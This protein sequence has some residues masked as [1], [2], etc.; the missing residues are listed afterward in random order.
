MSNKKFLLS[1]VASAIT[2]TGFSAQAATEEDGFKFGGSVRGNYAYNEFNKDSENKYGDFRFD[3]A[4]I[5]ISGKKDDFGIAAEYRFKSGVDFIKYGYGFYDVNDHMQVQVGLTQVPFGNPGMI[6]NSWWSSIGYYMGFEDHFDMGAK[7]V[8]ARN[9]WNTD[10]AFFKGSEYSPTEKKSYSAN[11]FTGEVNG[12]EYSNEETNQFNI[13]QTYT[14]NYENGRT[15][16]GGSV[17]GGQL[18]DSVTKKDGDRFAYAL[19]LDSTY[20]GWGVQAQA[21]HY[22]FNANQPRDTIALAAG[23]SA[24]EI[25]S[26]AQ[27]YIVNVYKTIPTSFGF[28]KI[29]NDFNLLTPEEAQFSDTYQNATGVAVSAGPIFAQAD[30]VLGKNSWT[31][32][33]GPGI[34]LA[35]TT[36]QNHWDK[37]FNINVGYY[38]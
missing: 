8:Y 11:V 24:Y 27:L 23:G 36:E 22:E 10:I 14:I 35:P 32:G 5:N 12:T 25:A 15:I 30:F 1:L 29:Y 2:L 7:F 28:V 37:T 6:S 21:M 33:R 17:Q 38:F 20:N 26:E 19:H 4:T 34:G 18:Y 13:R 9:G 31:N 16:L 3:V